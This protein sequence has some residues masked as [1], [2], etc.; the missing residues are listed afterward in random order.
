[1][2]WLGRFHV[3]PDATV[4]VGRSSLGEVLY[5]ILSLVKVKDLFHVN[6]IYDES[7]KKDDHSCVSIRAKDCRNESS[8]GR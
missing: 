3:E 6:S 5:S 4:W 7:C 2:E 8:Q 1:M